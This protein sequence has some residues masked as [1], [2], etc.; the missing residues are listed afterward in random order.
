MSMGS[1]NSGVSFL[2]VGTRTVRIA[3]NRLGSIQVKASP[4][5]DGLA[6]LPREFKLPNLAAVDFTVDSTKTVPDL[7]IKAD[8]QHSRC[9]GYPSFVESQGLVPVSCERFDISPPTQARCYGTP[10]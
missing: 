3:N 8:G 6:G 10:E 1:C 7:I 9:R 5:V 4:G 2:S